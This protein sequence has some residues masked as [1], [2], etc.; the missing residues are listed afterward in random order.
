MGAPPVAIDWSDRE[1]R[2]PGCPQRHHRL[3]NRCPRY[4]RHSRSLKPTPMCS[5][6]PEATAPAPEAAADPGDV[7][8]WQE[9]IGRRH[10][11][12][13]VWMLLQFSDVPRPF[14][15]QRSRRVVEAIGPVFA[16]IEVSPVEPPQVVND[17]SAAENQDTAVAKR[18]QPLTEFDVVFDRLQR[19][20]GKLN[21][22]NIRLGIQMCA[23][24]LH[25]P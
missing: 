9:M 2:Y 19:I 7:E 4:L 3:N 13:V 1:E 25:V 15:H 21:H 5:R 24:T 20:Q 8:Q 6:A 23:S 10:R 12:C 18:C 16:A 14:R 17:V 11:Q 22:R